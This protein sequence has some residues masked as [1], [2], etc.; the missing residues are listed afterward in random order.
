M[1]DLPTRP[2]EENRADRKVARSQRLKDIKSIK[3]KYKKNPSEDD[4]N[5]GVTNHEN[6]GKLI[7][8]DG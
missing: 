3:S 4:V 8:C 1:L 6:R 7:E 5:K 2:A